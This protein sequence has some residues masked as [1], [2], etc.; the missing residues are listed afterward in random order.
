MQAAFV[1]PLK[2]E[3]ILKKLLCSLKENNTNISLMH[4]KYYSQQILIRLISLPHTYYDRRT[5]FSLFY[6][7]AI[8]LYKNKAIGY[9]HKGTASY[10]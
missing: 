2:N 6:F 4:K 9:I 10:S 3:I 7:N 1:N 5:F 8:K